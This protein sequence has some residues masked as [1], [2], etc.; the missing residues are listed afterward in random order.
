[1]RRSRFVGAIETRGSE[2]ASASITEA[3]WFDLRNPEAP[4]ERS[5]ADWRIAA[6][7]HI[8]LLLGFTH[9]LVTVGYMFLSSKMQTCLCTDNPLIPA[10]LVIAL[11]GI[12]A[13]AIFLRKRFNFS[14]HTMVRSLCFYLI[15]VGLL[16]TWFGQTVADDAF[17]APISAAQ[18]VMCAGIAMGAI[19]SIS[20]PPLALVNT[21]T[22]A[23]AAIVLANSP[24]IPMA[25]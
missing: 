2:R 5:L 10:T 4:E 1:M 12:A 14:P 17:N 3:L 19:V 24:L 21:I 7:E 16:W 22:A 8:A 18:I 20:S 25:V 11:D 13:A 6:L 9:V 23:T 15:A